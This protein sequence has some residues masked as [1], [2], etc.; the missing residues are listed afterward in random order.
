MSAAKDNQ[1][2]EDSH[3][4]LLSVCAILNEVKKLEAMLLAAL[5]MTNQRK[6]EFQHRN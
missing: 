4:S 5:R 2:L 3:P 1:N 6:G